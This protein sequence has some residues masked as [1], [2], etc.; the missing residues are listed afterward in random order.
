MTIMRMMVLMSIDD[1][2]N[3]NQEFRGYSCLI[4]NQHY[5]LI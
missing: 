2:N 3:C 5:D 1:I 4:D